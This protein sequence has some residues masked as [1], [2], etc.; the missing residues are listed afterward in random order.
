MENNLILQIN[1]HGVSSWHIMKCSAKHK[2]MGRV[3]TARMLCIII[4]NGSYLTERAKFNLGSNCLLYFN[5]N[6]AYILETFYNVNRAWQPDA[7]G[8]QC[9]DN[10][11]FSYI[12]W[13]ICVLVELVSTC[14]LILT[15]I[16]DLTSVQKYSVLQQ[17]T[18]DGSFCVGACTLDY[19]DLELIYCG[20]F[21]VLS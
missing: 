17:L 7:F 11:L 3:T 4:G 5:Y 2:M 10:E 12:K 6:L 13:I 19:W 20:V 18:V 1:R 16:L 9:N 15:N 8:S 14:D 21:Y